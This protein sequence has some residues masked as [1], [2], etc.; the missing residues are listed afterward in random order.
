MSTTLEATRKLQVQ[1]CNLKSSSA[2][3]IN[4]VDIPIYDIK[5]EFMSDWLIGHCFLCTSLGSCNNKGEVKL[6][7]SDLIEYTRNG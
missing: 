4:R 2:A 5:G 3:C 7:S 1:I 6:T